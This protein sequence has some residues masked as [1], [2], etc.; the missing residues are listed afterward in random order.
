MIRERSVRA[1]ACGP[2][3]A[4]RDACRRAN[5][6]GRRRD[7]AAMTPA[8]RRRSC[9]SPTGAAARCRQALQPA[10]CGW[11]A[12]LAS[13][14]HADGRLTPSDAP[15]LAVDAARYAVH[16]RAEAAR[17]A[18]VLKRRLRADLVAVAA[19]VIHFVIGLVV[20]VFWIVG[21]GRRDRRRAL[22]GQDAPLTARAGPRPARDP[23]LLR[24][25]RG[26]RRAGSR[27][28]RSS[29]GSWSRSASRSSGC[30]RR[31]STATTPRSCDAQCPDCGKVL[32]LHDA[33]CMRC[34]TE[35]EFPD[36][37]I[38]SEAHDPSRIAEAASGLRIA[39]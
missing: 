32:K 6:H 20:A 10:G 34:G 26:D 2:P 18:A 5:A 27:A 35:L 39:G 4:M 1:D 11:R 23:V 25:G 13:S 15:P 24:P 14:R 37:A 17:S 22:G 29:S 38:A 16:E 7:H 30:W 36:V 28:A 31:S 12:S 33:V 9:C 3:P 21:G 19:L 8:R